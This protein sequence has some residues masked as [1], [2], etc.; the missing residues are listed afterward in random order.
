MFNDY[1]VIIMF[2]EYV[3]WKE[4]SLHLLKCVVYIFLN[5]VTWERP[6]Y[7]LQNVD[8]KFCTLKGVNYIRLSQL[9]VFFITM[10]NI[11]QL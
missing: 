8:C 4:N 11:D 1:Y 7:L 10:N 3:L 5:N 6:K 2:Y 9:Y